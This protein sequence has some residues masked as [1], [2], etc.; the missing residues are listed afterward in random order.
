MLV[1]SGEKHRDVSER[2]HLLFKLIVN[3]VKLKG[4]KVPAQEC[5]IH[6]FKTLSHSLGAARVYV[7]V[8]VKLFE[9]GKVVVPEL[10]GSVE[11]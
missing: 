3:F 1:K 2:L 8:K 7:D 10:N 11:H 4:R 5:A 9:D 6:C